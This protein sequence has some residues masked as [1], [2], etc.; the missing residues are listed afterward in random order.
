MHDGVGQA[1]DSSLL[2]RA[3]QMSSASSTPHLVIPNLSWTIALSSTSPESVAGISGLTAGQEK[4]IASCT[5]S[6]QHESNLGSKQRSSELHIGN[7]PV[8]EP[9]NNVNLQSG[10]LHGTSSN[11]RT[12]YETHRNCGQNQFSNL[13]I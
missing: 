8:V 4:I 12:S 1:Q 11:E 9:V 2:P 7:S 5:V 6:G 10:K 3:S 13:V